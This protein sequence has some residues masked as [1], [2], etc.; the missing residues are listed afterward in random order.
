MPLYQDNLGKLAPETLNHSGC[1][2]SKR[3]W[4]GSGISCTICES[5][6]SHSRQLCQ[7]LIT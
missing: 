2:W 5:F 7:R 1:Q 6:L 4:G 3:W